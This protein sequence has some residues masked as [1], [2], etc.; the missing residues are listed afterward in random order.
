MFGR[1]KDEGTEYFGNNVQYP[2]G[3][4]VY[5]I[6]LMEGEQILCVKDT[7]VQD[8]TYPGK[9]EKY[10]KI[11][12]TVFE[13]EKRTKIIFIIGIILSLFGANMIF[14]HG[15]MLMTL[16]YILVHIFSFILVMTIIIKGHIKACRMGLNYCLTDRRL[17]SFGV[18]YWQEIPLED[19]VR[20]I[21]VEKNNKGKLIVKAIIDENTKKC[22]DY[23]FP[24]VED[25]CRVK[26]KLDQAIEKCKTDN[27]Q[28]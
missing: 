14:I 22:A 24:D 25:P 8:T 28:F 20:T 16:P 12:K 1:K 15:G 2:P 18:N 7:G 9:Y 21:A 27:N 6:K 26:E 17:I 19:V 13:I 5:D 11:V 3:K 4:S 23:V 10:E